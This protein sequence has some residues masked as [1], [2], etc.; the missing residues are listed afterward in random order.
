MQRE[1][2]A[3]EPANIQP[4]GFDCRWIPALLAECM[5]D[6]RLVAIGLELGCDLI[7][8]HGFQYLS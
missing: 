3:G 2:T 7:S 5:E 6:T 8:C 4:N 1:V